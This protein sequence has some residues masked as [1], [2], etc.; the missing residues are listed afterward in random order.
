MPRSLLHLGCSVSALALVTSCS[1]L[2]FHA[3]LGS[4]LIT[5]GNSPDASSPPILKSKLGVARATGYFRLPDTVPYLSEVGSRVFCSTISFDQLTDRPR[6][7]W[8]L[9]RT[10]FLADKI[11]FDALAV[12]WLHRL[13]AD[14]QT[15]GQ[16]TYITLVGAPSP[17]QASPI[18][19]PA[20]HPTPLNIAM[21]AQLTAQ[22]ARQSFPKQT[23]LNWV[24]WNEPEH[25]LRGVNSALAAS[26]MVSIYRSYYSALNTPTSFG[27][28][29]G[30]ASFMK[31]SLRP[32]ADVPLQSFASLVFEGLGPSFRASVD[33]ITMNSYHGQTF[34][35]VARLQ[36]D[37]ARFN[38]DQPIVITQFTP[39]IIGA[40]PDQAGTIQAA[41]HYIS[42]LDHFVKT[43]GLASACMSFWAGPD[44]K[45]LLRETATTFSPSIPFKTLAWYQDLP[46]WRLP[47]QYPSN[48]HSHL[49]IA[50]R[51]A[52]RFQMLILPKPLQSGSIS[53]AAVKGKTERKLRRHFLR[54]QEREQVGKGQPRQQLAT[55]LRSPDLLR[56]L[57]VKLPVGP[58][59]PIKVERI[60][61]ESVVPL[62]E[63]HHTDAYSVVSLPITT[64][65]ILR[66]SSGTPGMLPPQRSAL[67][68]DLYV[69]RSAGE[70]G[71]ASVD[72][73]RDGFVLA[74]PSSDS[75]AHASATYTLAPFETQ[76]I[77]QLSSPDGR[78]G[79]MKALRCSS[80][81]VQSL[82]YG[83]PPTNLVSLGSQRAAQ[84]ILSSRAF[85]QVQNAD[86]SPIPWQLPD[87]QGRLR[88]N[89]PTVGR[90][91][92]LR[93]HL[94]SQ[95]CESGTQFQSRVLR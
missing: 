76:L 79:I 68:T 95:G 30:L 10:S 3:A 77:L 25:T 60:T 92:T 19:K 11:H 1:P 7:N 58:Y 40:Y 36:S 55:P 35:L 86:I 39:E 89:V 57:H 15:S 88:V 54:L 34:R 33:Y 59:Q 16:Q 42:Y 32:V 43:P 23:T 31:A 82:N 73:V 29:F 12:N 45:A 53:L 56:Q 67:R 46:L 61:G 27:Q 71:W 52:T 38:M 78:S 2:Y 63:N 51:D 90:A 65:Q 41:S 74:L 4:N 80:M 26:E 85:N 50:G 9:G 62:V 93:L 91:S 47:V 84:R 48:H 44:R 20:A 24:I 22:W 49:V 94:G 69:H 37:M 64:D 72:S 13:A 5:V 18:Q 8:A 21:S 66:L 87:E 17:F 14:L 83:R 70:Q 6:V 75:V 81:V 28:G